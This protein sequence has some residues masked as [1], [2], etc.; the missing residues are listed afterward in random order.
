MLTVDHHDPGLELE[1]D[2]G[3]HQR[4]WRV[5]RA[6]WLAMLLLVLA[7][8]AGLLGAGPLSR[9][10]VQDAGGLRVEHPR[11]AR[12]EA[13]QSLRVRMPAR[14]ADAHRLAVSRE[15][16]DRVRIDSVVPAPALTEALAD[17]VVYV[18]AGRP[19]TDAAAATFH[20]TP[21]S[22]GLVHAG[23]GLPGADPIRPSTIWPLTIW[24]VVYP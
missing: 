13:P 24:M 11:F 18:F 12:A 14:G 21:G 23:F 19:D 20:F 17:R 3:F 8:L 16:L 7:G 4:V 6:G 22:M 1:H 9:A 10:E 2:E 15:F 5:R